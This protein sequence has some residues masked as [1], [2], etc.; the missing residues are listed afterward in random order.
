MENLRKALS[1]VDNFLQRVINSGFR[2]ID[3]LLSFPEKQNEEFV[4][5]LLSG[6]DHL[7]HDVGKR[8]IDSS[9][10]SV[11]PGGSRF[12]RRLNDRSL[13]HDHRDGT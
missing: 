6:I 10:V 4:R 8:S 11:E 13:H 2:L 1:V 3:A 9:G 12:G 7:R 5:N